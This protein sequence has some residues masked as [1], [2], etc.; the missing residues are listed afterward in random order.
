MN[1]LPSPQ[2]LQ[3]QHI[4]VGSTKE[5]IGTL[6]NGSAKEIWLQALTNELGRLAQ[7]VDNIKGTNTL[8]F[9]KKEDI[10]KT[11][12]L[13]TPMLSAIIDH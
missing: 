10:P 6:I 12:K 7:G 13:L 3:A 9:V 4:Y 11:K 8:Q 1:N 2:P 5:T